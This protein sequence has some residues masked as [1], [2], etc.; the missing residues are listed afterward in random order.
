[1]KPLI[2]RLSDEQYEGL[3]TLA[4]ERKTSI[5]KLVREAIEKVYGEDME[6]IRDAEEEF[7]KYLADRKSAKDAEELFTQL[8]EEERRAAEK[9]D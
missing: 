8:E 3:R 5:A 4:F 9:A 1:M 2:C 6:D 7:A